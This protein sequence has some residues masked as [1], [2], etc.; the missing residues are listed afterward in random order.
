MVVTARNKFSHDGKADDFLGRHLR[1]KNTG[2]E[3]RVTAEERPCFANAQ[4]LSKFVADALAKFD[5]G[6]LPTAG[7]PTNAP[8]VDMRVLP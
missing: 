3:F 1:E 6:F 2:F 8:N 5:I 7:Q 4:Q